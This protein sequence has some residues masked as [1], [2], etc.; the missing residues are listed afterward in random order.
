MILTAAEDELEV[1]AQGT[2]DMTVK[3]KDGAFIEAGQPGALTAD[4]SSDA[5]T[6]PTGNPRIDV[7]E[8]QTNAK[9]GVTAINI[10]TGSEAGSPSAPS[11]TSGAMKLAE[12]YC[13]VGMTSIK[14]AD[15]STNGYITDSRKVMGS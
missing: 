8:I 11:V 7:V 4:T 2:P 3:V 9:T 5:I 15:D 12:I 6:A 13:R 14:D 10:V 1:V